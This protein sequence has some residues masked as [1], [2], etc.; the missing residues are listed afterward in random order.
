MPNTEP[1]LTAAEVARRCNVH[2]E[3]VRR[4][5]RDGLLKAVVLPGG[6]KRYNPDDVA[7]LT[8]AGTAA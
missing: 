6:H 8:T 2:P 5:T 1:L 3:T 4:W 7:A